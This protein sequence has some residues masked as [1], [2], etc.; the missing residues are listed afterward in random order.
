MIEINPLAQ[1]QDGSIMCMDAKFAFDD[2]AEFR[3]PEV[4]GM[5]DTSQEVG[6]SCV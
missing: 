5:R 6:E 2:N 3:Q 4:F 1:L